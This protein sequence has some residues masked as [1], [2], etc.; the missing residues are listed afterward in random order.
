MAIQKK[1]GED[2]KSNQAERYDFEEGVLSFAFRRVGRHMKVS[3]EKVEK[4]FCGKS[5]IVIK[6]LHINFVL[7]KYE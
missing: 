5:S 1:A 4:D 3:L 2:K 7:Y 6:V